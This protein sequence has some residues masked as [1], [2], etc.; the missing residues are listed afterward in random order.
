V[1]L[2]GF[3]FHSENTAPHFFC[4]QEPKGGAAW[5]GSAPMVLSLVVRHQVNWWFLPSITQHVYEA[6]EG[7]EE[8]LLICKFGIDTFVVAALIAPEVPEFSEVMQGSKFRETHV[9]VRCASMLAL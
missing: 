7:P 8:C 9:H 6:K 4:V 3:S 1:A 5:L 2:L